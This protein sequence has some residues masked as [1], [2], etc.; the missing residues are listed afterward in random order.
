MEGTLD[1]VKKSLETFELQHSKYMQEH[2]AKK[3]VEGG[4]ATITAMSSSPSKDRQRHIRILRQKVTKC[5]MCNK[6][7]KNEEV[8]YMFSKK[9]VNSAKLSLLH[10]EITDFCMFKRDNI[11]VDY[12]KE[13]KYFQSQVLLGSARNTCKNCF[14]CK[15]I[16]EE[17][18]YL[19]K[20]Q[21]LF[22]AKLGYTEF[23][24]NKGSFQNAGHAYIV[25][26][27]KV[28]MHT[29]S[30]LM[31]FIKNVGLGTPIMT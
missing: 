6:Y 16:I 24:A 3:K 12:F 5:Y 22:A 8:V 21:K 23:N 26:Q 15:R 4:T 20:L 11:Y 27:L 9:Q 2:R 7:K 14:Q 17:E 13:H 28:E 10:R 1:K 25:R 19:N 30:R 18:L 29:E 31:F